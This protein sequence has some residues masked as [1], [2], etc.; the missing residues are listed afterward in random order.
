MHVWGDEDFDWKQL[1]ESI[2]MVDSFM[3]FWG[4][5]GVSSKEKYGTARIYVTFW[6]GSLHGML[7]PG[8]CSSQ[9]PKWLWKFD[10]FCIGPFMRWTRVASLVNWYQKKI[11]GMAYRRAIKKYPKIKVE[12]VIDCDWEDLIPEREAIMQMYR[13]RS[14]VETLVLKR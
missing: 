13:F 7:Y 12:L 5:I 3:R 4:R 6:D 9:F 2:D 10:L 11:Y 1:S 8:W 14:F